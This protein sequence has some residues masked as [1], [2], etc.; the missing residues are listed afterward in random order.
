MKLFPLFC[1]VVA[2]PCAAARVRGVLASTEESHYTNIHI[3]TE[4]CG[5]VFAMHKICGNAC[6]IMSRK[7]DKSTTEPFNTGAETAVKF[8]HPQPP[9]EEEMPPLNGCREGGVRKDLR[10]PLRGT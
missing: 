3:R 7:S 6:F 2:H 10:P 8:S 4:M 9:V 1:C 5:L